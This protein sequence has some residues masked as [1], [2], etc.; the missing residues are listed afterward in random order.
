MKK[1]FLFLGKIIYFLSWEDYNRR[2]WNEAENEEKFLQNYF[3]AILSSFS[4]GNNTPR[5]L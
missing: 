2:R 5:H 3:E 1:S 4:Y